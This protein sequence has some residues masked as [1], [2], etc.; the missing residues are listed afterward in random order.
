MLKKRILASSMA[1]VMA[2]SGVSVAAFADDTAT[3]KT[4]AAV[5][6]DE[7]KAYCKTLEKFIDTDITD[8]G[9]IQGEQIQAA[10]DH[11]Q[12]VIEDS[13]STDREATAAYQMLKALYE[14]RKI[15]TAAQ[16]KDLIDDYKGIYEGNNILNENEDFQDLIYKEETYSAFTDAYDEATFYV[17]SDDSR[18]ITDAYVALESAKK[19]LS[20]LSTV[21]KS[22]FRAMMKKYQDLELDMKQSESWRRGSVTVVP[23]TGDFKNIKNLKKCV[24][25]LDD[26]IDIVY[27]TSRSPLRYY[28]EADGWQTMKG[29]TDAAKTWIGKNFDW[30]N[31]AHGNPNLQASIKAQYYRIL[32]AKGV[33]ETSNEEIVAAF[34]AAEDAVKVFDGWKIDAYKSGSKASAASD[35]KKYQ[36]QLVELFRYTDLQMILGLDPSDPADVIPTDEKSEGK[37]SG[38]NFVYDPAKHTLKADKAVY[39]VKNDGTGYI[40]EGGSGTDPWSADITALFHTSSSA[41]ESAK[42]AFDKKSGVKLSVQTVAAN[43]NLLTY[44]NFEAPE[45]TTVQDK[46]AVAAAKQAL[47]DAY[48]DA[49]DA[50]IAGTPTKAAAAD[51]G[52]DAYLAGTDI[53]KVQLSDVQAEAL[54]FTKA[55]TDMEFLVP[56]DP[57]TIAAADKTVI[58]DHNAQVEIMR[59]LVKAASGSDPAGAVV[60]YLADTTTKNTAAKNVYDT[61]IATGS[62]TLIINPLE[63]TK[64]QAGTGGVPA[65]LTKLSGDGNEITLTA[66]QAKILLPSH[67]GTADVKFQKV[68]EGTTTTSNFT[69]DQISAHNKVVADLIKA[70]KDIA[71]VK[72]TFDQALTTAGFDKAKVVTSMNTSKQK[73]AVAG[74]DDKAYAINTA[75]EDYDGVTSADLKTTVAADYADLVGGTV[76]TAVDFELIKA[77]TKSDSTAFTAAEIKAYNLAVLSIKKANKDLDDAVAAA[78]TGGGATTEAVVVDHTDPAKT[79]LAETETLRT[80]IE[81][82]NT[83]K[84]TDF[85]NGPT[86]AAEGIMDTLADGKTIPNVKGSTAEWTI[87]WRYL[88]Y[89]LEDCF[90]V[91]KSS[92]YT[93]VQLKDLIDDAYEAMDKTG[94]SALFEDPHMAVVNAREDA[95]EWYKLAKA[96]T[97]Y[98]TDMKIDGKKIDTVYEDLKGEV[99]DLNSWFEGFE[100]SYDDIRTVIADAAKAVDNGT[101]K[102]DTSKVVDAIKDCAKKLSILEPSKVSNTADA[103]TNLV[104]DDNRVFQAANRLKTA[105]GKSTDN[106]NDFEKDLTKAF[107]AL[108]DALKDAEKPADEKITDLDNDG[109]VSFKD[110][111]AVLQLS[112]DGTDNLRYDYDGDQAVTYKDAQ[113][114]LQL[115]VGE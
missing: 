91:T 60:K 22:E 100:Y 4:D 29:S 96:T 15:Y 110:A 95:L 6:V 92:S 49:K 70:F 109:V 1:S 90:P 10:Y 43:Q 14:E 103:D 74:T 30:V 66:D 56:K 48:D 61:A 11:A 114:L 36:S 112:V 67:T 35:I 78:T 93:L 106:P 72:D 52:V 27:G 69:A 97:G 98:K 57:A 38:V 44:I 5:S 71:D 51:I 21:K 25:S 79:A 82:Y 28:D 32:N 31:D 107:K 40:Y 54:G 111:Q 46:A 26:L 75:D 2:L 16:L 104:F 50:L 68:E 80:A 58:D 20:K 8:Y 55:A 81:Y 42:A 7:L 113:Y 13:K 47:A 23:T 33:T 84:T 3:S 101:L 87:V 63:S 108:K 105:K 89:A 83:Y 41:A 94:D 65:N 85:K 88:R 115:S 18:S 99:D 59:D 77:G 62:E 24:V 19:K 53:T 34:K 73:K 17:D 45:N 37:I 76:G 86:S 12:R 9:S 64:V 39:I 102:G